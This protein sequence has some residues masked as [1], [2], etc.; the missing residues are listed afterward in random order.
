MARHPAFGLGCFFNKRVMALLVLKGLV[1]WW[2][3]INV[4]WKL[5]NRLPRVHAAHQKGKTYAT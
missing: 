1:R 5:F 4:D 2:Q 3:A